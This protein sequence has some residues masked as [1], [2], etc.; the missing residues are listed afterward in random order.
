MK[1]DICEILVSKEE[2]Q[3]A[4]NTLGEI[5]TKD[6]QGRFPVFICILKGAA[7][8][9]SDLIRKIDLPLRT[10]FMAISSYG[11]AT[12]TSG[13]VRILKDLDQDIVGQD[14]IIVED[15]VD[16]GLTLSY[17]KKNLE[18]RGAASIK[19][20]TLL[21]KPARR[22]VDIRAD[23]SCFSIP[24][25]FVVGYGL[26]YDEKYRNFPEIGVLHPKVYTK[27]EES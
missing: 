10:E 6:Y 4:V 1:N 8:F 9:F 2:I 13:V 26:D 12:K 3:K 5:I 23:Y 14:V 15:I 7:I 25:S 11:S 20:V 24:D 18:D 21:D 16:T 19:I 17:L 27:A 22:K